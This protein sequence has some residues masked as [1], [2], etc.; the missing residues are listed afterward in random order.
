MKVKWYDLKIEIDDEDIKGICDI[1]KL[2]ILRT[3]QVK[4]LKI[5]ENDDLYLDLIFEMNGKHEMCI[6][7]HLHF[8]DVLKNSSKI[9]SPILQGS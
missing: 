1:C 4:H 5:I 8:L 2:P 3:A 6:M 9:S 7:D